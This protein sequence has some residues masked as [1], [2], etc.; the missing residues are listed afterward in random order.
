MEAIPNVEDNSNNINLDTT[1][2]QRIK[3]D[4]V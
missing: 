4:L 2:R 3:V 1:V